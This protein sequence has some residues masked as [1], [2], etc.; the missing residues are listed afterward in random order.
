MLIPLFLL[1]SFMATSADH[2]LYLSFTEID[3]EAQTIRIKAFSDDLENALRNF[4]G[5]FH[6]NNTV[7]FLRGNEQILQDYFRDKLLITLDKR[8]V[9][10]IYT[11]ASIENDAHFLDFEFQTSPA[12]R[13]M[14]VKA[15]F[16]MELF[17]SQ[18]NVVQVKMGREK[19]YLRLTHDKPTDHINF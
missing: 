9:T 5:S 2:A 16:F 19:R 12:V 15:D 3:V 8:P 14:E 4:E 13:E 10:L 11:S 7:N 6:G 1:T 17:P 18:S